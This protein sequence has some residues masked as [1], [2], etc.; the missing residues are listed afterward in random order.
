MI[1]QK[2]DENLFK[3]KIHAFCLKYQVNK[4]KKK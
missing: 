1:E 2:E 4:K 3:K